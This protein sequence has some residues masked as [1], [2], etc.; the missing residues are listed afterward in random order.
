[1]SANQAQYHLSYSQDGEQP[2]LEIHSDFENFTSIASNEEH[3]MAVQEYLG[4]EQSFDSDTDSFGY[5]GVGQIDESTHTP[6]WTVLTVPIPQND[7]GELFFAAATDRLLPVT[8][9]V[10]TVLRSIAINTSTAPGDVAHPQLITAGLDNFVPVNEHYSC[11]LKA[12][13][14]AAAL[15]AIETLS[16]PDAAEVRVRQALIAGF[17]YPLN[18]GQYDRFGVT[19]QDE[20]VAFD[21]PG[22]GTGFFGRITDAARATG[23]KLNAANN[24]YPVQQVAILCGLAALNDIVIQQYDI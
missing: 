11:P 19:L 20:V 16:D 1:M 6:G 14:S 22:D 17:E 3:L 12:K 4:L 8:A 18:Q 23:L 7:T 5:S 13:I 21:Y 9:T 15:L 24:D 10:G 2:V